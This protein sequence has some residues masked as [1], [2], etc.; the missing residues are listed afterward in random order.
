MSPSVSSQPAL[1]QNK[2]AP[3]RRLPNGGETLYIKR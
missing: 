1:D 3:A 2:K